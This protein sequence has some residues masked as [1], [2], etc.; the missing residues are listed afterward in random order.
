MGAIPPSL[1]VYVCVMLLRCG[2]ATPQGFT[3]TLEVINGAIK[4]C[5][6]PPAAA[7]V[8]SSA[9]FNVTQTRVRHFLDAARSARKISLGLFHSTLNLAAYEVS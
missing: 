1:H 3:V 2:A 4:R 5:D 7:G 6:T 8:H 9:A